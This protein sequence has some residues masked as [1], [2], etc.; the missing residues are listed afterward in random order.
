[1][2]FHGFLSHKHHLADRHFQFRVHKV[3]STRPDAA[4]IALTMFAAR[5][6]DTNVIVVTGDKF[7]DT[8]A[9]LTNAV[10][11]STLDKITEYIR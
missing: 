10:C 3:Q 4:D 8:L 7:G 1:M 2:A 6:E 11:V 5:L 9:E